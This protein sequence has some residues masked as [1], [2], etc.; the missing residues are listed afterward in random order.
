MNSWTRWNKNINDAYDGSLEH[1]KVKGDRLPWP[2]II[3]ECVGFTWGGKSDAAFRIGDMNQYAKYA[4]S[5]TS[6]A[7][8]N[9]IGYAST[10]GLAASLDPKRGMSYGKAL[11]GHRLLELARQNPRVDGFRAVAACDRLPPGDALES[12]DPGRTPQRTGIAGR[13]TSSRP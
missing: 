9:G 1:Y 4:R 6:W 5:S 3:W 11:F 7:Q 8:G 10:I 12:A 2:Y 13:R